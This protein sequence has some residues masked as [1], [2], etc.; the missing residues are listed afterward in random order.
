[1]TMRFRTL[2]DLIVARLGATAAGRYRV[3]G[4]KPDASAASEH[5]GNSRSVQVY[6]SG[7]DFPKKSSGLCGPFQHDV[8]VVIECM[9]SAVA[10]VDLATLTSETATAGEIAAALAAMQEASSVA[11]DQIDELVELVFQSIMAGTDIDFAGT[12][13]VANRWIASWNKSAP[14][15]RGEH[16]AISAKMT[17]TYRAD[18]EVVGETGTTPTPDHAVEADIEV[19][20]SAT[21]TP[22]PGAGVAAGG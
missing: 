15:A 4:Y 5:V 7:G 6:N 21:G 9:A 20:S 22:Q 18:E 19:T 10:T 1:M 16:V 13:P 3:I 2:K 12:S 8:E 11:D 17:L 14:L